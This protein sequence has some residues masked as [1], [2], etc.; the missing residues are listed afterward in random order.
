MDIVS[1]AAAAAADAAAT[2]H[3]DDD[4]DD[5]AAVMQHYCHLYYPGRA[6]I[7]VGLLHDSIDHRSYNATSCMQLI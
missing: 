3:D 4:D 2:D 1:T 7:V 5:D 6:C